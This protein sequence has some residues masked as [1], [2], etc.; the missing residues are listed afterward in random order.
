LRGCYLRLADFT[1]A[2]GKVPYKLSFLESGNSP[3]TIIVN[4]IEQIVPGITNP[5]LTEDQRRVMAREASFEGKP[6][7]QQGFWNVL[8]RIISGEAY[9]F[10]MDAG[11]YDSTLSNWNASDA[12]PW[13]LSDF[14][15]TPKYMGFKNG[16]QQVPATLGQFFTELG[17]EI[18]LK[19]KLEAFQWKDGA[20]ELKINGEAH[21]AGTLIL[22]M[23]RRSLDLLAPTCPLLQT[24]Q[25]LIATVTPRP[26]FKLFTTY[27]NPWWLMAGYTGP[28]GK[29]VPVEAGR[30]VTDLPVR[31]TY[32]WPKNDGSPAASRCCWPAMTTATIPASGMGCGRNGDRP[33]S[34]V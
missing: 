21:T 32:Y 3:G 14:G 1:A 11:G 13:Y 9:D 18:R 25:P 24:I 8:Y 5:S 27:S 26:L 4:A 16:F 12:I 20:F 6:L 33:G 29:F 28:D 17:G 22:A 15:I 23:P 31:Q 34:W 30:S 7:Y 19:S 2:P 10:S